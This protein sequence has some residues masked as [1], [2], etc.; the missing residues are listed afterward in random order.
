MASESSCRTPAASFAHI[1]VRRD[2]RPGAP[3]NAARDAGALMPPGSGAP[4]TSWPALWPRRR[5]GR[6]LPGLGLD[7]CTARALSARCCSLARRAG[8]Q[9]SGCCSSH[10]SGELNVSGRLR[11]LSCL[12][13]HLVAP[14]GPGGADPCVPTRQADLLTAPDRPM[15]QVPSSTNRPPDVL[16]GD[17]AWK[18]TSRGS[19]AHWTYVTGRG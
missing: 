16:Q 3:S 12:A 11:S 4:G 15:Q 9:C 1:S 5:T 2:P 19:S 17:T 14:T 7:G 13:K 10:A 18:P 6:T 8:W